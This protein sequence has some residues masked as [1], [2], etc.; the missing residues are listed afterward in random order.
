MYED[1][2]NIVSE[3]KINSNSVINLKKDSLSLTSLQVSG[4]GLDVAGN[5]DVISFK[6]NPEYK[7]QISIAPFDLQALLKTLNKK[8][9]N[10]AIT[11]HSP[12]IFANV[13]K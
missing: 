3:L 8:P 13:N 5:L 2:L 6:G 11:I 7:G 12:A 1:C 9:V 10:T 4:L